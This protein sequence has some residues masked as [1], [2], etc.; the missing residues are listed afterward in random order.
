MLEKLKQMSQVVV[1]PGLILYAFGFIVVTAYLSRFGI[2]SFDIVNSRFVIAGIYPL[3]SLTFAIMLAWAVR[4]KIKGPDLFQVKNLPARV[5]GYVISLFS[6]W[7]LSGILSVF[8]NVGKYSPPSGKDTPTFNSLGKYDL[9][10]SILD[11]IEVK[12]STG[13]VLKLTLYLFIYACIIACL[14]F[15]TYNL[16]KKFKKQKT[17]ISVAESEKP[18]TAI[19]EQEEASTVVTSSISVHAVVADLFF[20]SLIITLFFFSFVRLQAGLVDFD[21]FRGGFN[22]K[23]NF[24]FPWLFC[25][26]FLTYVFLASSAASFRE[27]TLFKD[28]DV[29]NIQPLFYQLIIPFLTS[30]FLFGAVVF[31]RIP[32]SIGGGEP[33][34]VTISAEPNFRVSDSDRVYLIGESSQFFFLVLVKPKSSSAVQL[35][36]TKV[37]FLETRKSKQ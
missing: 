24:V 9:I 2:I 15:L 22:T 28:F 31:P 27:R 33:R 32:F 13:F 11:F 21:S 30:L 18:E 5:E 12:G 14:I 16:I 1:L 7:V 23:D 3:I 10:G 20:L 29:A 17:G 26:A 8:F 19:S 4:K 35:N 6:L 37:N 34:E 25:S 36:K